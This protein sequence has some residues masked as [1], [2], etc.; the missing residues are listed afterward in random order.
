MAFPE[1]NTSAFAATLAALLH[2]HLSLDTM[3]ATRVK[4]GIGTLTL[5]TDNLAVHQSFSMF[6]ELKAVGKGYATVP[7]S[8]NLGTVAS[9]EILLT[10]TLHDGHQTDR[11]F[12]SLDLLPNGEIAFIRFG[13]ESTG[14]RKAG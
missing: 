8:N 2:E 13:D 3:P 9:L 10:G 12:A 11:H 4:A 6:R 1:L 7:E 5:E 14:L